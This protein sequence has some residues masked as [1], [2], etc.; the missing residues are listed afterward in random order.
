MP[1]SWVHQI[2]PCCFTMAS[3]LVAVAGWHVY[4]QVDPTAALMGAA[5]FVAAG[6]FTLG[7]HDV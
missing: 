6:L 1:L 3:G 2:A 4:A 7:G 5:A